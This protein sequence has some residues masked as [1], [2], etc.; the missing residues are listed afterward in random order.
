MIFKLRTKEIIFRNFKGRATPYT[1]AGTRSFAAIVTKEEA[2]K[3][4]QLGVVVHHTNLANR[5]YI[6]INI[7]KFVHLIPGNMPDITLEDLDSVRHEIYDAI[8]ILNLSEWRV[9]E[10][11]G[12]KAYLDKACLKVLDSNTGLTFKTYFSPYAYP[13]NIEDTNN[14]KETT[15]VNSKMNATEIINT[16]GIFKMTYKMM[17]ASEHNGI[18]DNLFNAMES[19]EELLLSKAESNDDKVELRTKIMFPSRGIKEVIFNKPATI[20][21][22]E[23]DVKTVVKCQKG[24][25]FDREKG[26]AMA[27]CK[28]LYGN[29]SNFNNL[30]KKWT[31]PKKVERQAQVNANAKANGK[32]KAGKKKVLD[33]AR[34]D[35]AKEPLTTNLER[36]RKGCVVITDAWRTLVK[37]KMYE[38]GWSRAKLHEKSDVSGVTIAKIINKYGTDTLRKDAF[39][40]INNALGIRW[41][42]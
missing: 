5:L 12:C 1:S 28:R 25:V 36:V 10:K 23:D 34:E 20:V 38:R 11:S 4:A 19:A 31:E 3:L 26:L 7:P 32:S 18:L 17:P 16:F 15:T 14:T 24:D 9:G 2:D 40:K 35:S 29:E 39:E 37:T 41:T 6:N 42:V 8:L 21:I 33:K 27:I 30:I 22:W 13:V